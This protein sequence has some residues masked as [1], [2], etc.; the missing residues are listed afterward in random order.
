MTGGIF[1]PDVIITSSDDLGTAQ[2]VSLTLGQRLEIRLDP[3]IQWSLTSAD[4]GH[5]LQSSAPEGWYDTSSNACVWRFVAV[6]AGSAQLT[7]SGLVLCQPADVHCVA[8]AET[9]TVEV[10][11]R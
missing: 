1:H 9:A 5:I 6:S 3:T 7:F 4:P 8:V 10:A 2:S 11:V